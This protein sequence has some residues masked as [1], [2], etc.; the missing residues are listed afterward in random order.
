M[1][2][3]YRLENVDKGITEALR[4]EKEDQRKKQE[5]AWEAERNKAQR[6]VPVQQQQ[7]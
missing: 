3:G 5:E 1:D 2:Y 7:G 4:K 6:E